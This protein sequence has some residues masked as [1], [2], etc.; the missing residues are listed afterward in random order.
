[1]FLSLLSLQNFVSLK[2]VASENFSGS[3]TDSVTKVLMKTESD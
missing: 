3:S 1:M 2:C